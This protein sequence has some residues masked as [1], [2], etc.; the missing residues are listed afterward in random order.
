MGLWW[1]RHGF[2]GISGLQFRA[3]IDAHRNENQ[4][5]TATLKSVGTKFA[6]LLTFPVSE[7]VALPMAA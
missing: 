7:P 6:K 5:K 1:A 3:G 2:D 4:M